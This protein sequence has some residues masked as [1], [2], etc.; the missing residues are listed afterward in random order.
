M[1]SGHLPY[2]NNKKE[3][4]GLLKADEGVITEFDKNLIF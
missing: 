1:K 2:I 4:A 3:W